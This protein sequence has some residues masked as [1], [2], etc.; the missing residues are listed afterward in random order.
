MSGE[1]EASVLGH[2]T[3]TTL[4]DTYCRTSESSDRGV[5]IQARTSR[6]LGPRS[7]IKQQSPDTET[8]EGT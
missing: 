5:A 2:A 4:T 8:Q 7:P 6:D 1:I 3:A